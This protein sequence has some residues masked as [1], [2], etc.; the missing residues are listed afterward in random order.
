VSVITEDWRWRMVTPGKGEYMSVPITPEAKR[1]AD[2][3]DPVRDTAAGEACRA[4]GAPGLIRL[5]GRIRVSWQDDVTLRAEFDA[6]SQTRLLHFDPRQAAAAPVGWQGASLA[7]WQIF[8]PPRGAGANARGGAA[9]PRF[10]HLRI[11]T[12][13]LRPGYL[14]KNGI[15]YSANARMTEQWDLLRRASGDQ[16]LVITAIIED[17][18]Y[19]QVPWITSLNFRREPDDS[20]FAPEPCSAE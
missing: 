20:K 16:W 14:R 15:P 5:P 7:E 1:V 9:A 17:P 19:L 6:G 10:G 18:R 11:T 4:Y 3:W 13:R 8:Q 2:A 12:T